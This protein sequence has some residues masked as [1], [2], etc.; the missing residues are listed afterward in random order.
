MLQI[1]KANADLSRRAIIYE[2]P[3]FSF[4]EFLVFES[5]INFEPIILE[6]II[7]NH[8]ALATRISAKIK[9]LAYLKNYFEYGY[10]P[11]YL[12]YKE[13]FLAR[14]NEVL[15]TVLE[16]DIPQF[17]DVQINSIP[18]IK[19]LL[20]IISE[21]APFKPNLKKIAERI[22]IS[23]NTLKNYLLYLSSAGL[24][25]MVEQQGK[26]I[27][28]LAKPEKI[29]LNNTNLMYALSPG[30]INIGNLRE[31]F[32][33]S[34]LRYEKLS[35]P[36]ASDFIVKD[37]YIFEIGGRNKGKKQLQDLTNSFVVKDNIEMGFNNEIPLWLFGF[38]Y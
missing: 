15:N 37:K 29:Y 35:I 10:Y 38:L 21:S 9:P 22:G 28:R 1:K 30:N 12:E 32:F 23:I 17:Q 4:R 19:Q 3:G 24:I 26:G 6:E 36:G 14:L 2:M 11:F 13:T 5:K 31:T 18:K 8:S 33:A 20:L 34:Q 27:N 25:L 16:V 7:K